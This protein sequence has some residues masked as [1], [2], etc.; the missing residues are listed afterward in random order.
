[1]QSA[2]RLS[3][4]TA[5]AIFRHLPGERVAVDAEEI[6]RFSQVAVH[7]LQGLGDEP[8]LELPLRVLVAN[9]LQEQ[10]RHQV[11]ELVL[12]CHQS[13]SRPVRRRYASRYLSRV[14][15][16]TSSGSDG[17]GGCLFQWIRSR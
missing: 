4:A 3:S 10:F 11:F 9:A 8:L 1:M 6:G 12:H 13:S 14:R 5:Q 7:L 17:T 15:A 2:D 16:T